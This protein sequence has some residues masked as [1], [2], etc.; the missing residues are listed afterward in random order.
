M[1]FPNPLRS[2]RHFAGLG[3]A[4]TAA[5]LLAACGGGGGGDGADDA[6][7]ARPD[8]GSVAV[9]FRDAPVDEFCEV[10]ATVTGIDLLGAD[11]PTNIFT[12]ERTV[13]VLAMRNM[14]DF[15]TVDPSVPIGSYEK[16]RLTLSDLAL[17]ECN[18]DVPEPEADWEHPNLPGNG[19]LDLNPRGSFE[20][21]GGEMLVIELDMDMEKSLH[22]HQAG[23]GKWL[24]RPV[25]FVT[26]RPDDTHLVRVFGAARNVGSTSFELCPIEPVS[27]MDGH[28][29]T[30]GSECLDV[31]TDA[32]TGIFDES[33]DR[34]DLGTLANDDLLTAI[35]FLG[36]HDDGDGDS[37]LDDLSLDAVVIEYGDLGTYLRMP[38]AVVSAPGN[39]GIFE[40]D[41]DPLDGDAID[42]ALQAGTRIFAIGSNVELTA[43]A[44]Q[45][46]TTGE[47]DGVFTEPATDGEPLKSSLIVLDQDTTPGT[48]VLGA[49][50]SKIDPD[51][52]AVPETRRFEVDFET[53]TAQC[54]KTDAATRYLEITESA[55]ASETAEIVFADLAVGDDVDVYGESI[56]GG[57]CVLA[58][59]VQKYVAAP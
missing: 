37:R 52:D 20:V 38:G 28:T 42:V 13:N 55:S 12:G 48:S 18:G 26:I 58:E 31:F 32:D 46:G 45:P 41:P 40:F 14:T 44:L 1:P 36:L 54:I 59:T 39:N 7:N 33:G 27:T 51:D 23:N 17:V 15:F 19:K 35:G 21:I 22:A 57:A 53:T 10:R 50:I 47:V 49:T 2:L 9:L 8:T 24:F 16:V 6:S 56:D 29:M 3:A 34:T 11:G 4:A 5:L 30:P 25:I 43:A